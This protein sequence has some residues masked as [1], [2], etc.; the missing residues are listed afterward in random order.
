MTALRVN[1]CEEVVGVNCALLER[2]FLKCLDNFWSEFTSQKKKEVVHINLCPQTV[3]E[4]QSSSLLASVFWN[5]VS[6]DT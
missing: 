4:L 2:T 5:F 3:C 1:A 6:G